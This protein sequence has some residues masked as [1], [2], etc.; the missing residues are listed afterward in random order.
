MKLYPFI[1]LLCASL[2]STACGGGGGAAK[3]APPTMYTIGGTV[4]GLVGTG[5][6]LQNNSGDKLP[7]SANAAFTFA[8]A[9]A[10]GSP[11]KVSVM[12]QPSSPTQNCAVTND[13]GT[14]TGDVTTVKVACTTTTVGGSIS[15]LVGT[16]L[17]LQNNGGDNLPVS[18]NATSFTFATA[19]DSGSSYKVSVLTQPSGPMQNCVVTNGSGTANGTVGTVSVACTTT[20]YSVGGAISGLAGTRLGVQN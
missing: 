16:G 2:F 19:V 9:V 3:T 15:G 20:T 13:S 4:S 11:Y 17:V 18:A 5:L 10:G 12:T 1:L 8:T 14:A 7:V 6:V